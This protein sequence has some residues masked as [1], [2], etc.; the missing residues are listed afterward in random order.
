MVS[1]ESEGGQQAYLRISRILP[2]PP[3][4]KN[5]PKKTQIP[6]L[7]DACQRPHLFIWKP[8][9]T[10]LYIFKN[11]S[12]EFEGNSNVCVKQWLMLPAQSY[13]LQSQ[14]LV[15]FL[16]GL[17]IRQV[18]FK[19]GSAAVTSSTW[20]FWALKFEKHWLRVK[21]LCLWPAYEWP[22]FTSTLKKLKIFLVRCP[23]YQVTAFFIEHSHSITGRSGSLTW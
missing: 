22:S 10:S 19:A 5:T 18:A 2:S 12:L 11:R 8:Y 14:F 21:D 6:S 23:N 9:Y 13:C 20:R 16:L 4:P 15:I 17:R 3:S 1:D 7:F